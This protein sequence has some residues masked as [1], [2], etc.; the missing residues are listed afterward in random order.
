MS[1]TR[2]PRARIHDRYGSTCHPVMTGSPGFVPLSDHLS[3]STTPVIQPLLSAGND[4]MT[5]DGMTGEVVP[6]QRAHIRAQ[7]GKPVILSSHPHG[8]A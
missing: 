6:P 7:T 2:A 3:S 5:D 8:G 4:P 1:P